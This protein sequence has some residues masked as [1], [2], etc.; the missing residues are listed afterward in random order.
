MEA[1]TKDLRLHTKTVLAAI[2]RGEEVL[3]TYH[4]EPRAR[5]VPVDSVAEESQPYGVNPAFGMW[6]DR[7][8]DRSVDE[9]VRRLRQRRDLPDAR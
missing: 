3:I 5:L 8:V 4:G 7:A 9:E 6:R 1:T 2:D